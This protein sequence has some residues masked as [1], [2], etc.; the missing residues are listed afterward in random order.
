[1][2]SKYVES[3]VLWLYYSQNYTVCMILS[4][5]GTMDRALCVIWSCSCYCSIHFIGVTC[6]ASNQDLHLCHAYSYSLYCLV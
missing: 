5:A 6:V 2:S 3:L 1:M 4:I